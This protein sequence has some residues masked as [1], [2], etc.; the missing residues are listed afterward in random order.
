MLNQ[1]KEVDELKKQMGQMAEFMGQIKEQGKLPSTTVVNPRGGFESVKA[2][3]L[4]NGKEVGTDPQPLKSAQTEDEKLQQE[5]DVQNTPTVRKE[6]T[7]P[8]THTLPN[9]SNMSTT[10]K[11]G[12]N[13]VNS[14]FI[15]PNAPF[16]RRFMQTRNEESEKDIL[17]TFRKVQVNIPFLDAIKQI[18]KYA[19]FLKKICKQ[20][21][22]FGRKR[23]YM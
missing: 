6:T 11:K 3:T 2:I 14:N 9:P 13:S 7:L 16:P 17:E 21:T 1:A 19:K 10:S 8:C 22:E 20:G 12:S 18:P 23:W 15:P 4:R 5:E